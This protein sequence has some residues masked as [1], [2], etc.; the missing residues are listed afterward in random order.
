[1]ENVVDTQTTPA[2][3]TAKAGAQASFERFFNA[4]FAQLYRALVIVTRD[5]AEAEDLAQESFVRLW[6]RWDRVSAL[7]DPQGY[8]YRTG[9]NG[10][11]QRRRRVARFAKRALGGAVANPERDPLSSI[12]TQDLIERSLLLLPARQRAA[13]VVTEL[14]GHD[15]S[16]AASILGVRPGTIRTLVSQA[17][18]CL[19][20]Q[21]EEQ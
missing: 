9:L 6:E 11:F 20:N 4:E 1:M 14:L 13:L 10:Y 17:K 19:R 2:E 8:L 18:T 21:K 12:E 5:T 3:L 16:E 15:S 7:D